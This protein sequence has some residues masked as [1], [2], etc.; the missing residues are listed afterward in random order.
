[1]AKMYWNT[2]KRLLQQVLLQLMEL[3]E[4]HPFRLVGGTALSLQHDHR[5]S[6]DIDLFTDADYGSINFDSIE[7]T[8]SRLF[9]YLERFLQVL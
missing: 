9:K 7:Q 2:V 4:L 3:P 1:M 6:V 5:I 8:L